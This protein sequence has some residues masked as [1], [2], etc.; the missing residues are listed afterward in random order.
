M[1]VTQRPK[2]K[3]EVKDKGG[4]KRET[5]ARSSRSSKKARTSSFA[6]VE[7]IDLTED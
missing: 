5:D 4:I 7:V 2:V 6:N 3:D 1:K